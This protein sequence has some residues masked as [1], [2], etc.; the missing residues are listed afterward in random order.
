MSLRLSSALAACHALHLHEG[1]TKISLRQI[2]RHSLKQ[3]QP[4]TAK[5]WNNKT[6]RAISWVL[7]RLILD[8]R[9][10]DAIADVKIWKQIKQ[11]ITICWW[12]TPWTFGIVYCFSIIFHV[13]QLSKVCGKLSCT[14]RWDRKQRRLSWAPHSRTKKSP[15]SSNFIEL[16]ASFRFL[17]FH[18]TRLTRLHRLEKGISNTSLEPTFVYIPSC[19]PGSLKTSL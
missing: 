13:F 16:L 19:K 6:K 5:V 1:A 14:P 7:H 11:K 17:S 10:L 4:N 8:S 9:A 2:S 12:P 18:R 15:Y 3:T